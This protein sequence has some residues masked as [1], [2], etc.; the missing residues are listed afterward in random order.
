MILVINLNP[1]VDKRYEIEDLKK[2]TVTRA[3]RVQNTAGG[4][5]IHV[6]SVVTT[7]KEECIV[8][9]F[10]GGKSGKFIEDELDEKGVKH[11]FINVNGETRECLALIT[12]D[13]SETE[14]LE[15]GPLISVKEQG[16]FFD[17]YYKLLEECSLV[18]A[19]GSVPRN[20]PEDFYKRLSEAANY[21]GK[22]FLLDTSGNLL[23]EGIKGKPYFIK[24]NKEEIE[25]LTGRKVESVQ[26][27]IHE[28]KIFQKMGIP[29]VAISLG[30][31]GS[32]VGYE[33][34]FY[35]VKSPKVK[36]VN[37]IGSGDS[38]VA[39]IA[40]GLERGYTIE[41]TL[42]LA[43]ACGSANASF[44]E[45]GFVQERFVHELKEK[46]SIRIIE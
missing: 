29:F 10:L 11:D 33:N 42:K 17:K 26:D 34:R 15:P 23:L 39:G 43:S 41:D 19:S 38:Y 6:A 46:V 12:D 36:L 18:V 14:I 45:T 4:K 24:P 2:N 3:R 1:S 27:V 5:G 20:I 7:L 37:S 21:K 40:I 8:T 30:E 28:I 9:G 35:E 25:N 16:M 22:R 31:K 44:S 32:I 13:L